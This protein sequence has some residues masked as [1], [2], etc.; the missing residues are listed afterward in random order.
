MT[1]IW[2]GLRT[3]AWLTARMLAHGVVL[4]GLSILASGGSIAVPAGLIDRNGHSIGTDFSNVDAAGTLTWQG[5]SADHL[6]P[7]VWRNRRQLRILNQYS[8]QFV[9]YRHWNMP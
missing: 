4:P 2:Q 7:A 5:R 1:R 3:G 8:P 9:N 6:R